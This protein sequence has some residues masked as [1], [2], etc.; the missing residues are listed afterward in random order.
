MSDSTLISVKEA[1]Q[2]LDCSEQYVRSLI[3]K[4]ELSADRIGRSWIIR[5]DSLEGYH[6]SSEIAEDNLADHKRRSTNAPKI[7]A[8]S[9]F[10]GAMGLDIGLERAGI[11][12]LLASEIAMVRSLLSSNFAVISQFLI[13]WR[14]FYQ[15]R[16]DI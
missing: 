9:F 5:E 13:L 8:L 15:T 14:F 2:Y 3:R 11:D 6:V 12:T 4:G 10:S 1:A 16:V 7:R